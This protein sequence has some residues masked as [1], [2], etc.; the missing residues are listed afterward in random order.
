MAFQQNNSYKRIWQG[1]AGSGK[2]PEETDYGIFLIELFK[3]AGTNPERIPGMVRIWHSIVAHLWDEDYH[4]DLASLRV[5]Y[6]AHI[7]ALIPS[8]RLSEEETL[9]LNYASDWLAL[10]QQLLKRKGKY[11]FQRVTE[12]FY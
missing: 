5:R 12:N 1:A 11:G 2:I 9:S 7:Q 4:K 8:R 10:I 6:Q 3:V